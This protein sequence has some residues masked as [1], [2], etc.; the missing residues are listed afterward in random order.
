MQR[1]LVTAALSSVLVLTSI[2]FAAA[3][4]PF[5]GEVRLF[6]YN[7]CPQGWAS[8]AGQLMQIN[9]NTALFSLFGTFYGGDGKSTFALPNL[10]GRAPVG[11]SDPPQGQPVGTAYGT[12]SVKLT[13][14]QLPAHS[15]TLQASSQTPDTN[16]PAGSLLATFQTPQINYA[17]GN[18]PANTAMSKGAI[19]STGGNEAVPTQSPVL[20]MAWCVALQGIFPSRQ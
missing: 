16:L 18:S 10:Q 4:S 11:F 1:S 7:F 13:V 14:A 17:Q 20:A 8:A 2:G 9:Q 3:Q 19:G 12:A 6:G 15:H 5:L